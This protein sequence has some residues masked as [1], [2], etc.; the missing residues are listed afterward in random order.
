MI[1]IFL[2]F[3]VATLHAFDSSAQ[4]DGRGEDEISRFHPGIMWYLNGWR[5]AKPNRIRKYDRLIFDVTYNTWTGD[6]SPFKH[7]WQ[8]LGLSTNLMF[9][10]PLNDS[11]TIS[12]GTGICHQFFTIQHNQ[13]IIVDSTQTYTT[14]TETSTQKSFDK[15]FIA[16]NS[17]LIPLE[18]R[19]R[20]EDWKHV[21]FHIGGKIGYQFGLYN[22]SITRSDLGRLVLFEH[23]F[24][25]DSHLMYSAHLR[26]GLR[27]WAFYASYNFNKF[28]K[29][30][31][32]TKLNLLQVGLSVSLF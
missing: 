16:G 18:L 7:P 11:N 2:I 30:T 3:L 8:S 19:F 20:K 21:K 17:I 15:S 10:I 26:F 4:Y 27:N 32:S 28:F 25:D 22:K 31:Q 12:F 24:P 6:L 23:G 9:D 29:N 5:P 13:S 14:Y 1:R